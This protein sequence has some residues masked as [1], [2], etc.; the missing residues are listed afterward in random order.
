MDENK[1]VENKTEKESNIGLLL[2]IVAVMLIG[3][4]AGLLIVMPN[5]SGFSNKK[6]GGTTTTNTDTNI[7]NTENTE[8]TEK[9]ITDDIGVDIDEVIKPFLI[10]TKCAGSNYL[11]DS[12]DYNSISNDIKLEIAY[13]KLT[14]TYDNKINVSDLL[15]AYKQVFG[16]DKEISLPNT[17][18][19]NHVF[20]TYSKEGDSYVLQG[21]GGGCTGISDIVTRASF[22]SKEN[23][24]LVIKVDYGYITT[25]SDVVDNFE[26]AECGFYNSPDKDK[27]L[28]QGFDIGS[29]ETIANDVFDQNIADYIL[30]TFTLENDNYIFD[31]ARIVKR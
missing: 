21:Q 25:I 11:A 4:G 22:E 2:L 24:K 12:M 27:L 16:S 26:T 20:A 7:E 10:F 5:E 28:K 23:N 15:S 18:H 6:S 29:K 14:N 3:V 1:K 17:L 30:Y 9:P 19:I 13:E 31:N 8:N